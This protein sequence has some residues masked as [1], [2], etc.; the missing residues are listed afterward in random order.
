MSEEEILKAKLKSQKIR[1]HETEEKLH[2]A[3]C[4]NVVLRAKLFTRN[5]E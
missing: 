1:L 4:E 3:Q 5:L 2:K